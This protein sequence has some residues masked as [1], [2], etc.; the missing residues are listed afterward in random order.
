MI[1]HNDLRAVGDDDV[2][3]GHAPAFELFHLF[4][5]ILYAERHTVA[6]DVDDILMEHT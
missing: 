4:Y 5:K 3:L 6:D 1:R 2:R